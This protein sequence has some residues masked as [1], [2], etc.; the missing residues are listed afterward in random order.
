MLVKTNVPFLSENGIALVDITRFFWG[1]PQS[2][3]ISYLT[4]AARVF[5]CFDP[6][7]NSLQGQGGYCLDG[8]A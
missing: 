3:N 5:E 1:K 6:I 8:L 2:P 4:S 7:T